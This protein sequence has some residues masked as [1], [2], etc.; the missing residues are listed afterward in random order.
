MRKFRE[1]SI[2]ATEDTPVSTTDS[3]DNTENQK[4]EIFD[5]DVKIVVT[6][7]NQEIVANEPDSELIDEKDFSDKAYAVKDTPKGLSFLQ[8]KLGLFKDAEN[9]KDVNKKLRET[10]MKVVKEHA[11]LSLLVG[12]IGLAGAYPLVKKYLLG[13]VVTYVAKNSEVIKATKIPEKVLQ[14]VAKETVEKSK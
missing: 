10:Q 11:K 7:A 5:E 9:W 2:E 6:E 3:V 13:T 1:P 4:R 12:T 14:T 8:E